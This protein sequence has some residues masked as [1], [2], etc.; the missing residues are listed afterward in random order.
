MLT[1]DQLVSLDNITGSRHASCT[2]LN[3]SSRRLPRHPHRPSIWRCLP[4]IAMVLG[5]CGAISA[6]SASNSTPTSQSA[7]AAPAQ[8]VSAAVPQGETSS[9]SLNQVLKKDM[10]YADARKAL[11]AQGWAPEKDL[12]CKAN[13]GANEAL[14]KSTPDLTVCRICDDIPELSAYSDEGGAVMHFTH[15]GHRLTIDASGSISDWKMSGKDSRLSISDW[16]TT[17]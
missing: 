15:A 4:L 14:C 13:V 5:P 9:A 8:S 12:Q 10:A 3:A 16:Q 7:P 2:R 1:T 6:C 17:K 11:L